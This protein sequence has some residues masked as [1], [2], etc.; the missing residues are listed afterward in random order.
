MGSKR[1]MAECEPYCLDQYPHQ[2]SRLDRY[3]TLPLLLRS[4][5]SLPLSTVWTWTKVK[6]IKS[7]ILRISAHTQARWFSTRASVLKRMS[8]IKRNRFG[9][10]TTRSTQLTMKGHV[11]VDID[12]YSAPADGRREDYISRFKVYGQ[13][14]FQQPDFRKSTMP[15][16]KLGRDAIASWQTF[17]VHSISGHSSSWHPRSMELLANFLSI[18]GIAGS[19]SNL[20]KRRESEAFHSVFI[21]QPLPFPPPTSQLMGGQSWN[22]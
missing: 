10:F 12:Q 4:L 20:A 22:I 6:T 15:K 14:S 17:V 18:L 3:T 8:I 11:D 9:V 5:I 19:F 7:N 21:C 13:F 1:E 2:P 16:W